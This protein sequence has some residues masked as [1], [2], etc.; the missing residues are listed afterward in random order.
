MEFTLLAAAALG[1]FGSWAMLWW[2]AKEGNA[3]RCAGSL[4]DTALFAAVA[5]IFGGRIVTMLLNGVNPLTNPGDIIIVRSGVSTVGASLIAVAVFLW[6][7]RR[8][9][10]VAADAIAAAALAGLAGWQAG[11][12][13][14]SGACLGSATDLPWAWAQPGSAVTRHPVE[15]YA[16]LAYLTAAVALAWWKAYRRPI[17][18]MPTAVAI[19]VAGAVRLVTEPLRPSL[20]GGPVWFYAAAIVAGGALAVA[21]A[22]RGRARPP[23]VE[24]QA[25]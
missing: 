14:R 7:F 20:G 8:Q 10:V 16:A 1:A 25:P 6:S 21:A 15:L 23:A 9:P 4:W 12:L 2:E 22:R 24:T 11:C 19:A 5:G 18:G 13:F 3:D 17:P